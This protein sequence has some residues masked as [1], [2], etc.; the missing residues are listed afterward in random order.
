MRI[1]FKGLLKNLLKRKDRLNTQ[2]HALL[3]EQNTLSDPQAEQARCEK[4]LNYWLDIELFDLPE[5]PFKNRK[6]ILSEEADSFKDKIQIE[7]T[8]KLSLDPAQ[9]KED[10][11]L[12]IMFQCHKA[13]YIAEAAERHPNFI[14]PRTYLVS[15]SFVPSW[16]E[17]QRQLKWSLSTDD[18]DLIINLATIRTIYRKCPPPTAH[19]MSLSQWIA[20][21]VDE[22]ETLFKTSFSDPE[23]QDLFAIEELQ[24]RIKGINRKLAQ[25]FWPETAAREFMFQHCQA[26]ESEYDH[27]YDQGV[28]TPTNELTF[29]W[30]YSYYPEGNDS[31]QLGPFFVQDLEHCIHNV[32][33]HGVTAL[34]TPLQK[35]L[36]GSSDQICVPDALNQGEFFL[37]LTHRIPLGRWPSDPQYGLSLLQTVAVN[38]AKECEHNPIVAVN[39]P[40]GTGKTTLLKDIIADHVVQRTQQLLKYSDQD[41]WLEHSELIDQIMQHSILVA[42]SNNKAVENISKELPAQASI[43]TV[44]KSEF[45][46]F[47]AAANTGEWGTFC[48]VLGNAS[49]RK[50]FK[51]QL[52]KLANHL[53][54]LHDRYK[55][56]LF[57]NKLKQHIAQPRRSEVFAD[58]IQYWKQQQLIQPMLADFKQC[59]CFDKHA[60]IFKPLSL[61]LHKIDQGQLE[62][63]E[64]ITHSQSMDDQAWLNIYT[65]LHDV[66]KQWF[67]K[68]MGQAHQQQK[69]K[70]AKT[71]FQ[72]LYDVLN[73]ALGASDQFVNQAQHRDTWQLDAQQH[74]TDAS[75]YQLDQQLQV[76]VEPSDK[77]RELQQKAPF[78][79][80]KINLARSKLFAAA[81]SLNQALLE[82]QAAQFEDYWNDIE[83]LIDGNLNSNEFTPHHQRL[84]S[85][86]FLFFPVISTSLSSVESQFKLM[87]KAQGFGVVMIDEAGQ[88]VNYHLVGLLQRASQAI[89]VGDP[90]QLEPVMTIPYQIDRSIAQDYLELGQSYAEKQWGD[91]YLVSNSSA[92]SIADRAGNYYSNIGERRVGIPLLVHRRC[93]EPMFSIANRIA[94]NNKMVSASSSKAIAGLEFIGSG[95][96]HVE[97]QAQQL[98]GRG[99]ANKAEA[100]TALELIEYLAKHYPHMLKGGVFVI[101]PFSI[102]KNEMIRAWK[103]SAKISS[104][105]VWMQQAFGTAAANKKIEA[106]CSDNIGTVHTFQGKEASTVI[107]C[108]AASEVR[109]KTGGIKWVN[110]KPNLLNVAVTRAKAHLFVIGNKSDWANGTLSAE[111]QNGAM[112][113]YPSIAALKQQPPIKYDVVEQHIKSQPDPSTSNGPDFYFGG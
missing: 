71:E 113:E 33:E 37:P 54:Y 6:D 36:L 11:R 92:Q 80:S 93:L 8:E 26:I 55:L 107:F 104:N 86:L 77:E 19:N 44:F 75:A 112:Y 58:Q 73:H 22:I 13:G 87:Q 47:S 90:I 108:A 25:Q 50:A 21:R 109:K 14:V 18:K 38:V 105:H 102:M 39:G 15:H 45:Q 35:Y 20:S 12:V 23:Q 3:L 85:I 32:S 89:F 95:W 34:S 1:D 66:K 24:I 46:H 4:I 43:D 74:L 53:K 88:A 100:N 31:Q 61:A 5:C 110:S 98:Q 65:A 62:I 94:Y 68:K 52:K 70:Q 79:S 101:T 51:S 28:L 42:S 60:N 103:G 76:N 16:D 81:L 49:N 96:I 29:R 97:E 2:Q 91:H 48:A 72:N 99:Y 59:S 78:S 30:R 41:N 9:I 10:S 111:L 17:E 7:L 57:L 84:W 27:A 83:A 106:F 67:A 69:L 82:S 40:P 64:F 63:A 56:N